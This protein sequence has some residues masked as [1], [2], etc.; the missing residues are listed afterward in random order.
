MQSQVCLTF[1]REPLLAKKARNTLI[2]LQKYTSKL[3]E[4]TNRKLTGGFSMLS[5]ETSLA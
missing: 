2:Y 4:F 5:T 3:K 1:R